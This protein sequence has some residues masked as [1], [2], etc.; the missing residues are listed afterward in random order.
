MYHKAG[1]IDKLSLPLLVKQK[2]EEKTNVS[3][4]LNFKNVIFFSKFKKKTILPSKKASNGV[5]EVL[6]SAHDVVYYMVLG[7][8]VIFSS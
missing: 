5:K 6:N 8:P 3:L 1:W 4:N 2:P 7:D